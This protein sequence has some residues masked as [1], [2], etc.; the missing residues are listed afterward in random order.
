M[1]PS[2]SRTRTTI[3]HRA[4]NIVNLAAGGQ[5]NLRFTK[6]GPHRNIAFGVADALDNRADNNCDPTDQNY[7]QRDNHNQQRANI[8]RARACALF[9]FTIGQVL[10]MVS[11]GR[12][13][14]HANTLS[15]TRRR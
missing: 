12:F 8:A 7:A 14:P 11:H 10:C 5:L 13:S 1:V 6:T 3:R 4:D 15:Y 9:G 2:A